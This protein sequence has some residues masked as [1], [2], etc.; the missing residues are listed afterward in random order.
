MQHTDSLT[1]QR[2]SAP[3]AS[4]EGRTGIDAGIPT[5][6]I[7]LTRRSSRQQ[8]FDRRRQIR[9]VAQRV[10]F[11][12]P[13][14]DLSDLVLHRPNLVV[15]QITNDEAGV[16]AQCAG[17]FGGIVVGS[18]AAVTGGRVLLERGQN[19]QRAIRTTAQKNPDCIP[20]RL[21]GREDHE[22]MPVQLAGDLT[23]VGASAT[24][25]DVARVVV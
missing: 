19:A 8:L 21:W 1:A 15:V 23:E 20:A 6:R 17:Y 2:V 3:S 14:L 16:D 13:P 22:A 4:L 10:A 7:S 11:H 9:V 5:A 12:V 25:G 18:I 24:V